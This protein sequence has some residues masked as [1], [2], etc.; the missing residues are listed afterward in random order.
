MIHIELNM[1]KIWGKLHLR[2]WV[3]H[4]FHST[5][6]Q[7]T[8]NCPKV[9][10][11]NFLRRSSPESTMKYKMCWYKFIYALNT[12]TATS[13]PCSLNS[14]LW[15][16]PLPN[17]MEIQQ[18]VYSLVLN[19]RRP[20]TA[21]TWSVLFRYIIPRSPTSVSNEHLTRFFGTP[22]CR[23]AVASDRTCLSFRT[24][25]L[26]WTRAKRVVIAIQHGVA[27]L[28]LNQRFCLYNVSAGVK[29][30]E[31]NVYQASLADDTSWYGKA[32]HIMLFC[33]ATSHNPLRT[34][35][36]RQRLP[37]L[38]NFLRRVPYFKR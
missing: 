33:V 27:I 20:N 8:R 15:R 35:S 2:P 17:F 21:S 10:S 16:T 19:H 13:V 24:W 32:W 1:Q 7:G 14:V 9:S 4:D 28:S 22:V 23:A 11:G 26:C 12:S 34:T 3:K 36:K 18:T 6:L 5:D 29:H 31:R 37:V 25:T 30:I 38:T